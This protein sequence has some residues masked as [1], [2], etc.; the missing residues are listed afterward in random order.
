MQSQG[1]PIQPRAASKIPAPMAAAVVFSVYL[2]SWSTAAPR[3]R[4]GS[5]SDRGAHFQA[6]RQAPP[7]CISGPDLRRPVL[8]PPGGKDIRP[9]AP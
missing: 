5:R 8:A 2:S 1:L 6:Y 9:A 4:H 7:G 3:S